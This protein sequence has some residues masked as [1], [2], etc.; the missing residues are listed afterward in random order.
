M[1]AGDGGGVGDAGRDGG[2]VMLPIGFIDNLGY[3]RCFA[4]AA[5]SQRQF[6]VHASS[7]PHCDEHC[8][9]CGIRI[10]LPGE[11]AGETEGE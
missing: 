10:D 9:Q 3:L 5:K 11:Y 1:R 8:D 2:R 4:C 6:P 7:R